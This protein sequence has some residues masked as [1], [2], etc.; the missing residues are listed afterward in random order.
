MQS[1]CVW[2]DIFFGSN[3]KGETLSGG[4][5][6]KVIYLGSYYPVAIF[7]VAVVRG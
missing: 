4:N 7:W 6:V 2:D 5:Y 1:N 3:K